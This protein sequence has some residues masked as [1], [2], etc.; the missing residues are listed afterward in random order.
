LR[1]VSDL[2]VTL[3]QIARMKALWK[4]MS[5]AALVVGSVALPALADRRDHDLAR[6]AVRSGQALP[7]S[8]ILSQVRPQLDGE[9]VHVEFEREDG[10]FLYE[11]RVIGGDGR[12]RRVHVDAATARILEKE[13]RP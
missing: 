1:H 5:C 13:D 9:I 2:T 7:L 3:C 4:Q 11:F 10:R 12:L 6:D 8:E